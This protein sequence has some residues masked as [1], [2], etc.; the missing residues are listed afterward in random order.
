MDELKPSPKPQFSIED[1]VQGALSGS[2]IGDTSNNFNGIRMSLEIPEFWAKIE[3][4]E[5]Y[6]GYIQQKYEKR[7]DIA[8]LVLERSDRAFVASYNEAME[9]INAAIGSGVQTQQQADEVGLRCQEAQ[10]VVS[11]FC[12]TLRGNV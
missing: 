10:K 3:P 11:D 7:P 4:V 2:G 5:T 9:K 1:A 12:Q 6:E 8:A